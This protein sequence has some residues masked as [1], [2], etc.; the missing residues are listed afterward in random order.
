MSTIR[1][2]AQVDFSQRSAGVTDES[3]GVVDSVLRVITGD[4]DYT[5]SGSGN[6][7]KSGL[8][9]NDGINGAGTDIDIDQ[10][11]T[12][13]LSSSG[14]VVLHNADGFFDFCQENKI[15]LF[16]AEVIIYVLYDSTLYYYGRFCVRSFD[17]KEDSVIVGLKTYFATL[18]GSI[19]SEAD[20]D[21]K[22]VPA[23]IG[24]V[25]AAE[26]VDINEEPYIYPALYMSSSGESFSVARAW[27]PWG[28]LDATTEY[29]INYVVTDLGNK[30][31]S[32]TPS[33]KVGYWQYYFSAIDLSCGWLTSA[34]ALVGRTYLRA[35]SGQGEGKLFEV[36]Y[37]ELV[38][39]GILRV[40]LKDLVCFWGRGVETEEDVYTYTFGSPIKC[41]WNK[42]YIQTLTSPDTQGIGTETKA[43]EEWE[44]P[45]CNSKY[46]WTKDG[47]DSIG[48][49]D[50][51]TVFDMVSY[52]LTM[53][54]A[55][56]EISSF[57]GKPFY[58][59][60]AKELV[61]LPIPSDNLAT[62][63]AY[64]GKYAGLKF[65]GAKLSSDGKIYSTL[66]HY[67]LPSQ[68]YGVVR[69]YKS[70]QPGW[71]LWDSP[72]WYDGIQLR[73]GA[74]AE[75]LPSR[76]SISE[77]ALTSDFLTFGYTD[78]PAAV[79]ML[80]PATVDWV[81]AGSD[82]YSKVRQK[83][84]VVLDVSSVDAE[85]LAS[86]YPVFYIKTNIRPFDKR[87]DDADVSPSV[88]WNDYPTV[89]QNDSYTELYSIQS[90]KVT[91]SGVDYSGN[92]SGYQSFTKELL[93]PTSGADVFY[94]TNIVDSSTR[95]RAIDIGAIPDN[96]FT[97]GGTPDFRGTRNIFRDG[98]FQDEVNIADLIKAGNDSKCPIR[99]IVISFET[100]MYVRW[101]NVAPAK[102]MA[103][104]FVVHG[105]GLQTESYIER[106]KL[107]APVIGQIWNGAEGTSFSGAP[108]TIP[109]VIAFL[110]LRYCNVQA[111]D[112]DLDSFS[113]KIYADLANIYIGK[114]FKSYEDV[115]KVIS[116]LCA[117]GSV[118]LFVNPKTGKLTLKSWLNE[119]P[120]TSSFLLSPSRVVADSIS[121]VT[122][123]AR[124]SITTWNDFSFNK[125]GNDF[126]KRIIVKN[127]NQL[128]PPDPTETEELYINPY[129]EESSTP[130]SYTDATIRLVQFKAVPSK[131][132]LK[133]AI[134]IPFQ[135]NGYWTGV[136]VG[137]QIS[138][139][140]GLGDG[141]RYFF[142][143]EI[144]TTK[145]VPSGWS[146][147]ATLLILSRETGT[148]APV[149][150][151]IQFGYRVD[152][153]D[154]AYNI[155]D[156]ID[157]GVIATPSAVIKTSRLLVNDYYQGIDLTKNLGVAQ[158]LWEDLTKGYFRS[159]TVRVQDIKESDWIW[160]EE[161]ALGVLSRQAKWTT[162]QHDTTTLKMPV[163]DWLL[164]TVTLMSPVWVIDPILIPEGRGGW[165]TS[166]ALDSEDAT[167]ELGITY[168]VDPR[169]AVPVRLV[170]N[171]G[172]ED[173]DN[174]GF[175]TID[176]DIDSDTY[177]E[178]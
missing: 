151:T 150:T 23:T 81:V 79:D 47:P 43:E 75:P 27:T 70:L 100:L 89:M 144:V 125:I 36:D 163:R 93:Q 95:P 51:V 7:W 90:V 45:F 21:A 44:T 57:E 112:M 134:A 65:V 178:E 84:S 2:L 115:K 3:R 101:D 149:G 172:T 85:N 148:T 38:S 78:A 127:T 18:T 71:N 137:Q 158:Y 98:D 26:L 58:V 118:V 103:L 146:T 142:I 54:V 97:S 55:D 13:S 72:K 74:K 160:D 174:T 61:E 173:Q 161:S 22:S 33:D 88:S 153:P 16:N 126:T 49:D 113:S 129:G 68:M 50:D 48:F 91:I 159:E 165:L 171:E 145:W 77:D 111:A 87:F 12:F 130:A 121:G 141:V 166:V 96:W 155:P 46:L 102:T 167:V 42:G 119:E 73:W 152:W 37:L 69:D 20:S 157:F 177:E 117:L 11:G 120:D 138:I 154:N 123:P 9:V 17:A 10:G 107:Y 132:F 169:E 128:T 67:S 106:E 122:K 14:S 41:G 168:G 52:D 66:N 92:L 62:S 8:L 59:N 76:L 4:E 143:E 19:P 116:E 133:Y 162:F 56:S 104:Q 53:L 60:Q 5:E 83:F 114:S 164:N 131:Y 6:V 139:N 108:T 30:I 24:I 176:E 80:D 40:H 99:G 110:L 63:S 64:Q 31:Q 136:R 156:A 147:T 29:R 32:T 25:G 124:S 170:I 175:P 28:M 39:G 15:F 82:K 34:P 135:L 140:L 1:F 105:L 94:W 109:E 35:V 86:A